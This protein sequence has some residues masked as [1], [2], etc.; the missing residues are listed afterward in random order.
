M[1]D[2]IARLAVTVRLP[3]ALDQEV[4]DADEAAVRVPV[5]GQVAEIGQLAGAFHQMLGDLRT[6]TQRLE[7]LVFKLGTLNELVEM[8]THIPKIQDLL[9]SVL[10][11]TMRA[12]HANIGSIMLL[13]Q[14]RQTLRIAASRGLSDQVH[15]QAEVRLGEGVAGKVAQLGDAVIVDDI[16]KDARFAKVNDPKY[17]TGSFICMP[18][19]VGDRVIGVINLA[20]KEDASTSPPTPRPFS[21]TDLQFLTALLTYIGYAVDNARLLQEAQ[22]SAGQL[23]NVV[24]DLRATQAQLV[25]GETLTAIGKLASGMAHHLNNLFAVILGRLE[26]L[27]GKVPDPETRHYLE[28]VQR[29]AQDGAEVVRRVQ[30]FSRVQPVSR[31]M[32]VDLNQLAQEVLDMTRPRWHNEALLRQIRIDTALDLGGIQ[33][34]AGELAPLREVLMNLVLNAIDAMP[35]GGRLGVKTWADAHGV[36]CD[37]SDSGAGMSE[38][39]RQRALDP[40]FTTKGPKS[41]GLGLSVTYGIIQ[42]HNGKLEID[43]TPETGTTVHITLPAAGAAAGAPASSAPAPASPTQLR[44]LLVDDEPEVRSALADMLATSGHTAFQAAGGK[45]AL[46]WLEAGQPVDL[47]LTDLGMPGMTGADVARA[48][49]G[50]WPHLRLGLMTGWDETEVLVAETSAVVDFV[51]AKPFKLQAL[52][53][54]YAQNPRPA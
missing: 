35:D 33:P 50:R 36:H 23:Q 30:R 51:I 13:D 11:S 46:A 15:D 12:V 8:S 4:P 44:V 53:D 42:R 40:F 25:R 32:P 28:I 34:V 21:P 16:E 54:A 26:T 47:V 9:A 5:L 38:E 45:E 17:G 52:L 22:Q 37:V 48:V 31:T 10:Q 6:S 2:Q 1:V 18:V 20:K 39:V 43:S 41:T 7:D 27:Q 19:R 24:D 49:R 29:A 14:Q 3:I